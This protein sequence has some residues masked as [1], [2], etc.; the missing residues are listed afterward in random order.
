MVLELW[1]VL[2]VDAR[3]STESA[4]VCTPIVLSPSCVAIMLCKTQKNCVF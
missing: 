4:L 3:H 1:V 2:P